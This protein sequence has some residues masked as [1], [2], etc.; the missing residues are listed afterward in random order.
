MI[1]GMVV[2]DF[3]I[4]LAVRGRLIA[5]E[6]DGALWYLIMCAAPDVQVMRIT[7]Q[8]NGMKPGDI[9]YFG[10]GYIRLNDDQIQLDPCLAGTAAS[11]GG[12]QGD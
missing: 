5:V 1:S 9:V 8:D 6:T 4:D 7:Y 2:P 3:R 10:G 11:F 12:D